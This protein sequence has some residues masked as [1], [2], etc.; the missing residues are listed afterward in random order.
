MAEENFKVASVSR[1]TVGKEGVKHKPV[2]IS[3][4]LLQNQWGKTLVTKREGVSPFLI[5]E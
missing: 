4:Q 5:I 1:I 2:F 3:L